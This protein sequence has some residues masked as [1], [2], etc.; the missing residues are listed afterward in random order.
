MA[1]SVGTVPQYLSQIETPTN[2]HVDR[3]PWYSV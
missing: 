1:N 3:Y 2:S